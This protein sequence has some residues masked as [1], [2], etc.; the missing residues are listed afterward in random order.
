MSGTKGAAQKRAT[1]FAQEALRYAETLQDGLPIREKPD[2]SAKRIYRLRLGE[3][4]KILAQVEGSPAINTSGAPL[5]GVWYQVLTE[6]GST[7]YCFSYRLRL[8]DYSGGILAVS[9]PVEEKEDSDLE[10]LLSK[11]WVPEIYQTMV[12]NQWINIEDLSKHWGFSPGLDTGIAHIYTSDLDK[13]FAYTA[14]KPDGNRSWRFE[15]TSL[16]MTLRSDNLLAVQ[17]SDNSFL[18]QTILFTEFQADIEDLRIQE[19]ERRNAAYESIMESGPFFL[20]ANYGLLYF[21][22]EGRFTWTGYNLLVPR[23]VSASSFG[24]GT[25]EMNI[26]VG[27]SLKNSFNGA[28]SF[29]F[30]GI[31]T[32]GSVVNMLYSMYGQG[33]RIEYVPDSNINESS[34]VVRRASSPLVIY[35]F[36]TDQGQAMPLQEDTVFDSENPYYTPSE[37]W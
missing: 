34:V 23:I 5:A 8:F 32:T 10:L 11:T 36:R 12:N 1:A 30:E 27:N 15:G 16:K 31:G 17:Y 4:I 19:I 9:R 7:G 37:Q 18:L 26:F 35:F 22:P 21:S 20:S 24:S 14:I 25:V 6:N 13:T 28:F 2:N 29:H 3:I 33:L